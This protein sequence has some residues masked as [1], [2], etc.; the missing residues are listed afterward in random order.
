M[1][2]LIFIC[3]IIGLVIALWNVIRIVLGI[4]AFFLLVYVYAY[5]SPPEVNQIAEVEEQIQFPLSEDPIPSPIIDEESITVN[6]G[7][8]KEDGNKQIEVHHYF[9]NTLENLEGFASSFDQQHGIDYSTTHI[10][11]SD[12]N[13]LD[14][15]NNIPF[16]GNRL[17]LREGY[18]SSEQE[19]QDKI[20]FLEENGI[21]GAR[22]IWLPCY[23]I[24][25]EYEYF[26]VV[27][28]R[29][30][31]SLNSAK[32]YKKEYEYDLQSADIFEQE[33]GILSVERIEMDPSQK[34]KKEE[35]VE[36]FSPSF[37]VKS[38]CCFV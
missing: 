8:E 32:Q 15:C 7:L 18:Y 27:L 36:G 16:G 24:P 21:R 3:I 33:L 25:A 17:F 28:G 11:Q 2:D 12:S 20:N 5:F 1:E 9:H 29:P 10:R 31:K 30:C 34:T 26:V 19:A 37:Y 13:Q 35:I 38:S 4:A 23:Q 22:I 14:Y 6:K